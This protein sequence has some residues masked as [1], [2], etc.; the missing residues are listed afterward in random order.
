MAGSEFN[1]FHISAE[2]KDRVCAQ[3]ADSSESL[4]LKEDDANDEATAAETRLV[5]EVR[6]A[7]RDAGVAPEEII[8]TSDVATPMPRSDPMLGLWKSKSRGPGSGSDGGTLSKTG[9]SAQGSVKDGE[10]PGG[11]R[12]LSTMKKIAGA[13]KRVGT[14]KSSPPPHEG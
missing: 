11:P 2:L 3:I 14:G 7:S 13:L 4:P 12:R 9:S 8:D 1:R 10:R 6:R 5:N